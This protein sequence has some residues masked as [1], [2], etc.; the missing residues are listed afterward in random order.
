MS[1]GRKRPFTHAKRGTASAADGSD[2][3]DTGIELMELRSAHQQLVDER[4]ALF[5]PFSSTATYDM[6]QTD[7]KARL[8]REWVL[9][10]TATSAWLVTRPAGGP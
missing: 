2:E 5:S 9:R 1:E 4:G 10:T 6:M 7:E 8:A 3:M